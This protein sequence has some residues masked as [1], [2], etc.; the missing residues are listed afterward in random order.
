MTSCFLGEDRSQ[1]LDGSRDFSPFAVATLPGEMLAEH[2]R[3]RWLAGSVDEVVERI[4]ELRALG[5]TRVPPAPEPLG[6]R[7]MV[8]LIGERL[9]PSL[10]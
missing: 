4:A 2:A 3:D 9:L 5:V 10:R 6:R 7:E 1:A 8:A